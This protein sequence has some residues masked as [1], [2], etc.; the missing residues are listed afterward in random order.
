M[1]EQTHPLIF[2]SSSI[3][4]EPQA[5]TYEVARLTS[6]AFRS[7]VI[8]TCNADRWSEEHMILYIDSIFQEFKFSSA[9]YFNVRPHKSTDG[10]INHQRILLSGDFQLRAL[11]MFISGAVGCHDLL[12][13]MWYFCNG[14]AD[15]TSRS[16]ARLILPANLKEEFIRKTI[17]C[18]EYDNVS[19]DIERRLRL[20]LLP[21]NSVSRPAQAMPTK[22][23]ETT[24]F[25]SKLASTSMIQNERPS[26][27]TVPF[28]WNKFAQQMAT[29]YQVGKAFDIPQAESLITILRCCASVL[30]VGRASSEGR[31]PAYSNLSVLSTR[32]L[33]SNLKF[34]L[35][36]AF[37]RLTRL[38]TGNG[39]KI[40]SRESHEGTGESEKDRKKIANV[41]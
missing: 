21:P 8:A 22:T 10:S 29:T 12:G 14:P 41:G 39:L 36:Q 2:K 27:L 4:P 40:G 38:I 37:K 34:D 32:A 16:H 18:Y 31:P 7:S 24:H 20:F 6:K 11:Q 23:S 33:T 25:F 19:K 5:F 35:N 3:L 9:I 15:K 26:P 1:C 17:Q 13:R 28:E 30:E